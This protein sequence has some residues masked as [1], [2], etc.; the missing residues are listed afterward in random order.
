M[1]FNFMGVAQAHPQGAVE[2]GGPVEWSRCGQED[3]ETS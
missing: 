3:E 1:L 2:I